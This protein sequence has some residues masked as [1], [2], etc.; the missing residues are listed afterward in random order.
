M[1]ISKRQSPIDIDLGKVILQHEEAPLSMK[2]GFN[3]GPLTLSLMYTKTSFT[4]DILRGFNWILTY[5]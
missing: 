3:K 1:K 4:V 2:I 5:S